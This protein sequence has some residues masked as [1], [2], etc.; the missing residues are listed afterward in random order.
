MD[1]SKIIELLFER[2][3]QA[4][5]ELSK[6]YGKSCERLSENIL[7]NHS[8]VEECV[9]DAYLGVWNSIPPE[10]PQSLRAYLFGILRNISTNR[11]H[12]NTAAK[13]NCFYDEALDEIEAFIP[14]AESV[15]DNADAD[16]LAKSIDEFLGKIDE[17]DQIMFVKRYYFSEN[18]KEIANAFGKS[19]KY[20]S[21]R[22]FRIRKRL[23]KFLKERGVFI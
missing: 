6:K 13:R 17:K 1:D 12:Y 15:E 2:S 19:E 20:I 8:D 3:E 5:V 21:V 18:I 16:F 11:Y 10:R 9:N 14:S 23:E 4:L 22:L 7:K